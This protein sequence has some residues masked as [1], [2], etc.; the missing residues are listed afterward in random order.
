MHVDGAA[1]AGVCEHTH[2]VQDVPGNQ[3]V[4]KREKRTHWRTAPPRPCPAGTRRLETQA[5]SS[6]VIPG[7]HVWVG[8]YSSRSSRSAAART[9]PPPVLRHRPPSPRSPLAPPPQPP[10]SAAQTP[11][12]QTSA[13]SSSTSSPFRAAAAPRI[14]HMST[15]RGLLI[16]KYATPKI[17]G[18]ATMTNAASEWLMSRW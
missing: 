10:R 12:C 14:I 2:S 18:S 17:I 13:S 1:G 15:I 16:E 8:A 3:A 4:K 11:R 5:I 6:E 7:D 9:A